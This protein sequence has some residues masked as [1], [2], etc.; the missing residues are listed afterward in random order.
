M[1]AVACAAAL[2][3]LVAIVAIVL[4]VVNCSLRWVLIRYFD[5]LFTFI[6]FQITEFVVICA[7][8][9][10]KQTDQDHVMPNDSLK[11]FPEIF[12]LF[13]SKNSFEPEAFL[14]KMGLEPTC[15]TLY[16]V[17]SDLDF[18]HFLNF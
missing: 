9:G 13:T 2:V 12:L 8:N 6:E 16:L 15:L 10:I 11:Y 1:A 7:P 17:P 5:E 4:V 18:V 3:E 14:I